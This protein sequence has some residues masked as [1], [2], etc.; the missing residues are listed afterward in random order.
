MK[1]TSKA[2]EIRYY[3]KQLL[4]DNKEHSV[5]EIKKYIFDNI[6]KEYSDGAYAGALRDLVAKEE[7]YENPRRGIYVYKS[8]DGELKKVANNILKETI[9]KLYLEVGKINVLTITQDDFKVVNQIK[10][11]IQELENIKTK[12]K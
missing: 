9:E 3:T 12:F 10:E 11:V 1:F 5:Q 7:C 8:N 2:E 4:E 6:G